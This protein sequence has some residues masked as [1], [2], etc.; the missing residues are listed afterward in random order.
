[1]DNKYIEV[2][3]KECKK[4]KTRC[5]TWSKHDICQTCGNKTFKYIVE[6]KYKLK[7]L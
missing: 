4:C 5:T 2:V 1:M 3:H 7:I 6:K